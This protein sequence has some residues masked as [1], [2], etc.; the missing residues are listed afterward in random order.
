[1]VTRTYVN[2]F[3]EDETDVGAAYG[4]AKYRRL[5]EIKAVYDPDNVFRRNANIK[6]AA[7]QPA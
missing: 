7:P 3:D 2:A 6:P 5:A 1:M 4:N